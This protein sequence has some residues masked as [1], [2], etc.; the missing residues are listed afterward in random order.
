MQHAREIRSPDHV[1]REALILIEPIADAAED[2]AKRGQCDDGKEAP[3]EAKLPDTA[4]L[5]L[6]A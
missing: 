6:S 5:L 4:W 1:E 2:E 3:M